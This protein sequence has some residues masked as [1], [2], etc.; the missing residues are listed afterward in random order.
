MIGKDEQR[1]PEKAPREDDPRRREPMNDA[2][3]APLYTKASAN[4]ISSKLTGVDFH[5]V[6]LN[7]VYK[8][9]KYTK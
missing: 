4:L 8:S 3:I 5:P 1:G 6:A 9:A 2:V 7:R